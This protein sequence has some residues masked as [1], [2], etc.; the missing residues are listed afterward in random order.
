[1]PESS[2]ILYIS[3]DALNTGTG[4]SV[5]V[6][7]LMGYFKKSNAVTF[8]NNYSLNDVEK[9]LNLKA[10]NKFNEILWAKYPKIKLFISKIKSSNIIHDNPICFYNI[11]LFIICKWY[12]KR[13][14]STFHSNMEFNI[15]SFTRLLELMRYFIVL[16]FYIIFGDTL[17]FVS[18]SQ[19]NN[20]ARFSL[21][22]RALL[23]KS[24]VIYN[25]SDFKPI[26][27][28]RKENILR[29]IFVGRLIE[30][31]GFMNFLKLAELMKDEDVEFLIVGKGELEKEIKP[32]KNLRYLG[33]LDNKEMPKVYDKCAILVFPSYSESFSL[34]VLEAMS[35]GLAVIGSDIPS[36]QE[37][38]K[39]GINGY[40]VG[41]NNISKMREFILELKN[42]PKLLSEISKN[43][44]KDSLNYSPEKQIAKY[45][46]AYSAK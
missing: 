10:L 43:N 9:E 39:D 29:I 26:K 14:V 20:L 23:K 31:K 38:I 30:S 6:N 1:M 27:I 21:F 35:R 46:L 37:C 40:T 17:I 36:I 34:V 44:I 7:R 15:L 8:R 18:E 33:R 41:S 2:K 11:F 42:N 45:V 5:Y 13:V 16:N 3:H 22:K 28:K 12:G 19:R 25:F 32:Q 4:S 24:M